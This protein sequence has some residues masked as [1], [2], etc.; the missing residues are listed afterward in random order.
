MKRRVATSTGAVAASALCAVLALRAVTSCTAFTDATAHGDEAAAPV[1]EG[2]LAGDGGGTMPDPELDAASPTGPVAMV[3]NEAKLGRI[4]TGDA[5][6][7]YTQAIPNGAILRVGKSATNATPEVVRPNASAADLALV[8]PTLYATSTDNGTIVA[9]DTTKMAS[10]MTAAVGAPT[11]LVADG[12]GLVFLQTAAATA[13]VYK[14]PLG[15]GAASQLA[16]AAVPQSLT[17]DAQYAYAGLGQHV[18]RLDR[19]GSLQNVVS[20]DLG[21]SADV[22]A[23]SG[24]LIYFANGSRVMT[25]PTTFTPATQ[26][27]TAHDYGTGS[28]VTA[29]RVTTSGVF[30]ATQGAESGGAVHVLP[31]TPASGMPTIVAR[32]PDDDCRL[33]D[34]DAD[35]T[36]IYFLCNSATGIG[37]VWRIAKPGL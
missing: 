17:A 4:L 33:P 20:V 37:S 29:I 16:V 35:D 2:G 7:Y 21:G 6:V 34:M 14:M 19:V 32:F 18:R 31:L 24:S 27:T 26:P 23:V 30:V 28:V 12:A 5:R 9:L 8:G 15:L 22:I 25:L 10:P 11:A 36:S 13:G 3:M 1:G